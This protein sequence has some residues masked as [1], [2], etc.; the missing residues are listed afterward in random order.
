MKPIQFNTMNRNYTGP[1][2]RDL[3]V[4]V[5]EVDGH[6]ECL[7]VWKPSRDELEILQEGGVVCLNVIGGQPPVAVWAEEVQFEE[8]TCS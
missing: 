7:S 8:V 2:C 4:F 1:D 6:T 5:E 3:P